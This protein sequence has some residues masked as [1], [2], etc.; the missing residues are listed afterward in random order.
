MKKVFPKSSR[1]LLVKKDKL[2]TREMFDTLW[3]CQLQTIQETGRWTLLISNVV[4]FSYVVNFECI[5]V[6]MLL[7][8]RLRTDS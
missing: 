8:N 1:C 5:T 7:K 3:L 2:Y 6:R 4:Y